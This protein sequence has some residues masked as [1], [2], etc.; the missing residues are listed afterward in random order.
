M[1][2]N[3]ERHT[4]TQTNFVVGKLVII[5]LGVSY[6]LN[7]PIATTIVSYFHAFIIT[8]ITQVYEE[9]CCKKALKAMRVL[10]KQVPANSSSTTNLYA[11]RRLFQENSKITVMF[12][13]RRV[14]FLFDCFPLCI[15]FTHLLG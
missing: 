1:C 6:I 15:T 5:Y 9:F 8:I 13:L 3:C 10:S 14:F 4:Q 7:N 2:Y 11:M 12:S